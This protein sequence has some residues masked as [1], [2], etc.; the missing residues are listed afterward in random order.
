MKLL[1][2]LGNTSVGK[3]TVGQEVVKITDFRL[4]HNHVMIEPILDIF[5]GFNNDVIVKLRDVVFQEFAKSD[6]YGLIFTYM[7]DFDEKAEWASR[8]QIDRV[9]EIFEQVNAEIYV[10]ELVASQE[11]RLQRNST[12]NRL[13][14]KASKLDI[15]RS[16]KMLI[17]DDV[18]YRCESHDGELSFANYIKIDNSNLP[19]ETV[20]KMIKEEFF[21]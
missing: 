14:N 16:N 21:S 15:E 2:I 11:V 6:L 13:R 5:G 12:E 9:C 10:V 8:K 4:F 1:I 7:W 3:M 20:A 18:D 19:P 17:N